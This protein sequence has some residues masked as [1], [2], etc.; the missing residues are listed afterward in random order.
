MKYDLLKAVFTLVEFTEK[1][2]V[3]ERLLLTNKNFIVKDVIHAEELI[4]NLEDLFVELSAISRKGYINNPNVN[5]PLVLYIVKEFGLVNEKDLEKFNASI[6]MNTLYFNLTLLGMLRIV[7]E[8]ENN[9]LID[10]MTYDRL[11]DLKNIKKCILRMIH[12]NIL[13]RLKNKGLTV[14]LNS[15]TGFD[16]EYEIKSSLNMTN[17]LLSVQLASNS[18]MYI[19]IPINYEQPYFTQSSI[20]IDEDDVNI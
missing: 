6:F 19:K 12:P 10:N 9:E 18:N 17:E 1:G 7:M 8:I 11:I 13:R 4:K 20:K 14:V 3:V 16:S 2:K 5:L 15:I